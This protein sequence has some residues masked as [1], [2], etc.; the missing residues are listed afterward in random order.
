MFLVH[1]HLAPSP[2]HGIGVFID[3]PVRKGTVVWRFDAR[4]DVHIPRAELAGFPVAVQEYLRVHAYVETVDGHETMVLCAD[5]AQYVNHSTA[6]NLIDS[7][8]GTYETAGRDLAAGE[9]LTCNY[10]VFDRAS[11]EKLGPEPVR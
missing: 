9:E 1:T 10:Y 2:I 11:G 8:D 5:S 3:E 7:P 6:P 4:I